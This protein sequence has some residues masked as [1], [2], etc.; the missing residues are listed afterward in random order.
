M[1]IARK[2]SLPGTRKTKS[3][4][5]NSPFQQFN[6][7]YDYDHSFVCISVQIYLFYFLFLRWFIDG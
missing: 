1:N 3:P 6:V 4:V 2:V 5:G 7:N